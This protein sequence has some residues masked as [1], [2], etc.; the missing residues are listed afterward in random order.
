M[1]TKHPV[2]ASPFTRGYLDRSFDGGN[3][4]DPGPK[5]RSESRLSVGSQSR[6]RSPR[7]TVQIL[8]HWNSFSAL[9]VPMPPKK[10]KKKKMKKK[11]EKKERIKMEKGEFQFAARHTYKQF[12][13][14]H[15]SLICETVPSRLCQFSEFTSNASSSNKC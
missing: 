9:L 4:R 10:K 12:F 11:K 13:L 5:S 6:D 8:G 2:C 14:P 7:S 1:L 15:L 3:E